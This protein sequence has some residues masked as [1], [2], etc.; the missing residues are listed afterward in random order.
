MTTWTQ[1]P[2][3]AGIADVIRGAGLK[4]TTPRGAVLRS[5]RDHPHA[6]AD[7]VLRS[8]TAELPKASLQSVYNALSDFVA[9]GIVRRF[10]PSG[11]P[12]LYELRVADNHHHLV[13]THCGAV[14]DVDCAVGHAPCLT[15]SDDHGFVVHT[16]EVTYWGMCAA[17]A[18]AAAPATP[19]TPTQA[20]TPT[21]TTTG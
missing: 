14:V 15:P 21:Q 11:K 5:L 8:V 17:C 18:S 12:G 9:A 7:E 10:E 3:D 1:A 2:L 4:F 13:C 16:A 20:T 19:T 6:S